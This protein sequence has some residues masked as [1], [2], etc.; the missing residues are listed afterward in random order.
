MKANHNLIQISDALAYLHNMKPSPILHGNLKPSN[1]LAVQESLDEEERKTVTWKL[2]EFGLPN[3]LNR[4]SYKSFYTKN[5][6]G[7]YNYLAPEVIKKEEKYS[8]KADIWSF[9]AVISFYF[10]AEHIFTTVPM[11]QKWTATSD[12]P[13]LGE[14]KNLV[15]R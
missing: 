9:G 1:I 6:S 7:K 10:N 3:L 12:I 8:S 13:L 11:V 14:T 2:A 5:A 15:V 4:D